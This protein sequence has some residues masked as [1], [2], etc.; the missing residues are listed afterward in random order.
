MSITVDYVIKEEVIDVND[1]LGGIRLCF[2]GNCI[3]GIVDEQSFDSIY[4]WKP[5]YAGQYIQTDFQRLLSRSKDL[6]DGDVGMY[7]EIS[8]PFPPGS[9]HFVLEP[10]SENHLRVA[11]RISQSAEAP[12]QSPLA[13]PESA[14]GYVVDRCDFCR[15]VSDAA[16]EYVDELRSMPLEW[17]LGLLDEFEVALDELD[18]A[19]ETCG[20]TSPEITPE[21][22][23]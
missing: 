22:S 23:T 2:D 10:L 18:E 6:A 11:Y 21:D 4:E 1:V 13:V 5:H 19:L 17:G 14:R 16:H 7:E 9:E 15:A 12:E 3:V 20:Q 8:V